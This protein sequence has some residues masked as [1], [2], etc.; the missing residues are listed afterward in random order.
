MPRG[1]SAWVLLAGSMAHAASFSC[2]K[3]RT[4]QEK[5][6][7]ASPELSAA[8]DRMNSAYRAWLDAAP[9][10]MKTEIRQSQR[11]WIRNLPNRCSMQGDP[12]S[13]CLRDCE[14]SRTGVL[15]QMVLHRSGVSFVWGSVTREA[16]NFPDQGS[17]QGEETPGFGT[18]TASWPVAMSAASQWAAWNRAIETAAQTM[19][20]EDGAPARG[21]AAE[22]GVDDDVSVL[23]GVVAP[24]LVTATITSSWDGHRLSG[25][26][27]GTVEFNWLLEQRRELRPE[28]L[29]RPGSGW[30]TGLETRMDG[31][32]RAMLNP[33]TC[34]EYAGFFEPGEN[35][36][37]LHGM[38]LDP[39]NWKIDTDGLSIY[40]RPYS[41]RNNP[42]CTPE[43]VR[44]SWEELKPLLRPEFA[45]PQ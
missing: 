33:R 35:E 5:A 34:P 42:E 21:W 14:A 13:A 20:T 44:M 39:R 10:Q 23:V 17:D 16:R 11:V 41:L 29:F 31:Y 37:T 36:K 9:A 27:S 45:I 28:D 4:P 40:F 18:L 19:S 43:P 15:E 12:L 6:I 24:R 7:C 32:L 26:E 8:D 25:P 38:E 2:A 3:A 30:E 22:P 1:L